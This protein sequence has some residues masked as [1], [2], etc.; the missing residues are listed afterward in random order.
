MLE[1]LSDKKYLAKTLKA[2]NQAMKQEYGKT[3]MDLGV[4]SHTGKHIVY[5][6]HYDLMS[7]N[8]AQTFWF[9][10]VMEKGVY[11]SDMFFGFRKAP[12]FIIAVSQSENGRKW[13]L[14]ATIYTEIFRPLVENVKT[15]Q[16]IK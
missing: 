14:M 13:I 12:H 3:F 8:Y 15:Y 2:M 5:I 16:I 6:G 10:E 7:R 4:I 1:H 11:I 9:K